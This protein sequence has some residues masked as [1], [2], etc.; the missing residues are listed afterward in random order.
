MFRLVSDASMLIDLERGSLLEI[1]F[2]GP[3]ALVVSDLLYETEIASHNGAFLHKIGLGVV[4]LTSSELAFAQD[5]Y[6]AHRKLVSL[7]D[8]FAFSLARRADYV[9]L[10]EDKN[11]RVLAERA[12]MPCYGVLWLLDEI[13]GAMP[14]MK[15]PLREGLATI[16]SHPRCRLPKADVATRLNL[17]SE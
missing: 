9:L 7:S 13:L 2:Q 1:A 6:N 14:A 5:L 15:S 3:H 17:W 8:C 16:S 12:E 4:T 11:V 10:S